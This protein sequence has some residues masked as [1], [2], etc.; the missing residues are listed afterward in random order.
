M[1][2][3]YH[4]IFP[5][6]KTQ[7]WVTPDTFYRQMVDIANKE[8]VYLDDYD[9]HNPDQ[10][11][12]TFDGVYSNI[13]RYATPILKHFGYPYELFVTGKYIGK[14]NEFDAPEPFAKF[15]DYDELEKMVKAGGRLQW[16]TFSH[17]KLSGHE[18]KSVLDQEFTPDE[19]LREIDPDGLKWFAYP[20]GYIGER[21]VEEAEQRGFVG[22]LGCEKGTPEEPYNLHRKIIYEE[23]KIWDKK[24]SVIIPAFNYGR[25]L[26]ESVESV[27]YQTY[28]VDEIIVMDD[29][30]KDE[31][32]E[33]AEAYLD[34]I[35]YVQNE[36]N[37]GIV[38]NFSKGVALSSGDY[39]A[40]LGA[41]NRYR[42]D[43][44]EKAKM[45]LDSDP[46]VGVVST[47]TMMFG[48][49]AGQI[50]NV[51]E[52][53]ETQPHEQFPEIFIKTRPVPDGA[54]V[55]DYTM[56]A[57]STMYRREAYDDAGGY[58]GRSVDEGEDWNLYRRM[59]EKGWKAKIVNQPVLEYRLHS[60]EQDSRVRNQEAY[61]A[62]LLRKYKALLEENKQL[63][64]QI[65]RAPSGRKNNEVDGLRLR[66]FPL[67][68]KRER[69]MILILRFG[70]SLVREG[71]I[72]A[73]KKLFQFIKKRI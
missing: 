43:F 45:I 62:N 24:I 40:F 34:Q 60:H 8:V 61:T 11:V 37:L 70:K 35:T 3:L 44:I 27:L 7:W 28:K 18:E 39:I 2:L 56:V 51:S 73:G 68:S 26:T 13:L 31:T 52:G 47:G 59:F 15:A 67:R 6:Q 50:V 4:K 32:K 20:Y 63:K 41:D 30:S 9:P 16:H 25:F 1:I 14:G 29:A 21:L 53:S 65:G 64:S 12:I 38:K 72:T 36:E 23:S 49:V 48:E 55:D 69:A 33:I 54:Y 66:L 10:V 46:S 42:A 17:P 19:K 71:P 22:A 5:E 57:G 58:E